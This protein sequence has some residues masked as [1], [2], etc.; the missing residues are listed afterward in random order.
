MTC[1]TRCVLALLGLVLASLSLPVGSAPPVQLIAAKKDL[2]RESEAQ[3][4]FRLYAFLPDATPLRLSIHFTP[5]GASSSQSELSAKDIPANG[6]LVEGNGIRSTVVNFNGRKPGRYLLSVEQSRPGDPGVRVVIEPNCANLDPIRR[7]FCEGFLGVRDAISGKGVAVVESPELPRMVAAIHKRPPDRIVYGVPLEQ[8]GQYK[9]PVEAPASNPFIKVP[10]PV[11]GPSNSA[12]SL[13]PQSEGAAVSE[14]PAVANELRRAVL[15]A[16]LGKATG[17]IIAK[18]AIPAAIM[19]AW[20]SDSRHLVCSVPGPQG[21]RLAGYVLTNGGT[22]VLDWRLPDELTGT[23]IHCD[24]LSPV[25]YRD[26]THPEERRIA[27]IQRQLGEQSLWTVSLGPQGPPGAPQR[28]S[29]D[30]QVRQL[31]RWDPDNGIVCEMSGKPKAGSADVPGQLW[32]WKIGAP[33]TA[34]AFHA[35]TFGNPP[36]W[37]RGMAQDG[38]SLVFPARARYWI[39]P[40]ADEEKVAV[41]NSPGPEPSQIFLSR[42]AHP[43]ILVGG[44]SSRLWSDRWASLSPDGKWL[45]FDSDRP[46]MR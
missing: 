14:T 45:V 2:F 39:S 28:L 8:P 43:T 12:L 42:P 25:W 18:H 1:K 9:Q 7:F 33:G 27:F 29:Q 23:L 44:S 24:Q 21:W 20:A 3:K 35:Y 6:W 41:F 38:Q 30:E 34:P 26:P 31:L 15:L 40:V 4:L 36:E 37:L 5:E 46:E 13:V 10:E 16:D 32:S 17:P 22:F 19:P 11:F